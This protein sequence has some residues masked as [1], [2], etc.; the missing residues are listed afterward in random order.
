MKAQMRMFPQQMQFQQRQPFSSPQGFRPPAQTMPGTGPHM[1]TGVGGT[2]GSSIP[3]QNQGHNANV[4]VHQGPVSGPAP[5]PS[6]GLVPGPGPGP[7]PG[8]A[9]ASIPNQ[10][11][12]PG[13]NQRQL[14]NQLSGQPSPHA[15]QVPPNAVAQ[16]QRQHQQQMQ[17]K[18]PPS[19]QQI[20]VPNGTRIA[21]D[22]NGKPI[23]TQTV[24]TCDLCHVKEFTNY[25]EAVAHEKICQGVPQ[26]GNQMD[27]GSSGKVSADINLGTP[28]V[29]SPA[30]GESPTSLTPHNPAVDIIIPPPVG[31]IPKGSSKP[32]LGN[33]FACDVCKKAFFREYDQAVEHEE[34][35]QKEQNRKLAIAA[36]HAANLRFN[37]EQ[38]KRKVKK[39][40][41]DIKKR[42]KKSVKPSNETVRNKSSKQASSSYDTKISKSVEDVI[43]LDDDDSD[44]S[45]ERQVESKSTKPKI[46]VTPKASKSKTFLPLRKAKFQPLVSEKDDPTFVKLSPINKLFVS[47]TDLLEYSPL[48]RG[49]R[50]AFRCHFCAQSLVIKKKDSPVT[51][52]TLAKELPLSAHD[53]FK[54]CSNI[55]S[56]INQRMKAIKQLPDGEP[57]QLTFYDFFKSFCAKNLIV[58]AKD[59][60]IQFLVDQ[61]CKPISPPTE[62]LDHGSRGNETVRAALKLNAEDSKSVYTSTVESLLRSDQ[63]TP[64]FTAQQMPFMFHMIY[65][66]VQYLPPYH[67][68]SLEQLNLSL[69]SNDDLP[70]PPGY[71]AVCIKCKH[72]GAEKALS[73]LSS[74]D[75]I[76]MTFS[77]LHL[78]G[79]SGCPSIPKRIQ[80]KLIR[81]REESKSV[82]RQKDHPFLTLGLLCNCIAIYYNFEEFKNQN[83]QFSGKIYARV[84][85][86]EMSNRKRKLDAV[87]IL[88]GDKDITMKNTPV[89]IEISSPTKKL[90]KQ[91][92]PKEL[93][94]ETTSQNNG[95]AK[96]ASLH[97]VLKKSETDISK[98]YTDKN[99]NSHVMESQASMKKASN[100]SGVVRRVKA[101]IHK[102]LPPRTLLFHSQAGVDTHLVPFG[103][104][105][106]M[107]SVT[108]RKTYSMPT[109]H[110]KLLTN[111]EFYEDNER[112]VCLRCN[113]CNSIPNGGWRTVLTGKNDLYR[114]VMLAHQ[115]FKD[116]TNTSSEEKELIRTV[117]ET[118]SSSSDDP[119]RLF[120]LFLSEVFGLS[121][122]VNDEGISR[123]VFSS[124]D[125]QYE[126]GPIEDEKES[127]DAPFGAKIKPVKIGDS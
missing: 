112:M 58:D 70:V 75:K 63:D 126:L 51:I 48:D 122:A 97:D 13:L 28:S 17:M 38:A 88:D 110:K 9:P 60:G 100:K 111:L 15:M 39:E 119:M 73:D 83:K 82:L 35:C 103:G 52:E 37:Q 53:H 16:Q 11:Q 3:N 79:E 20:Q 59:G 124:N 107:S 61:T 12:L 45:M 40:K 27:G 96:Q 29:N 76:V 56:R 74:W 8:P 87:E 125:C 4:G 116:C 26:S 71:R 67:K 105:P 64:T 42:K 117:G 109:C 30:V 92:V 41:E 2:V 104:V 123:L 72:C 98:P 14:P 6:T 24:W 50:I 19:K 113:N 69:Q 22:V 18:M 65:P 114:Q 90:V 1:N 34:L 93:K 66:L 78:G 99:L 115:H 101:S 102:D 85:K 81:Q 89:D 43:I 68:T 95:S 55:D 94:T 54:K 10:G 80:K 5:G 21:L 49:K 57:G 44:K 77:M 86:E 62:N 127:N 118:F 106:L 120:C 91:D 46:P 108:A 36:Y 23:Q 32:L 84:A 25:E 47:Y 33:C 31:P 7:V 121:D